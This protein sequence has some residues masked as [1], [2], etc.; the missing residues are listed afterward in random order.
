MAEIRLGALILA[1]GESKRMNGVKALLKLG[2][3]SAIEIVVN[4]YKEIGIQEIVV[5][6]G[7]H[8]GTIRPVVEKMGARVAIN[9]E[10]EKGM[11]SSIQ[12]GCLALKDCTDGFFMQ[13][14]DIP[15]VRIETLKALKEC[16]LLNRSHVI[17]PII[18]S[19]RGHPIIVSKSCY[20]VIDRQD[21]KFTMRD[22]LAHY[23]Y[24]H[25]ELPCVDEGI[26]WDMDTPEAYAQMCRRMKER[27]IPTLMECEMLWSVLKVSESTILHSRKV[28]E[29]ACRIGALLNRREEYNL[30]L[31]CLF[32]AGLMHD[33]RK[34]SK[35]HALDAATILDNYGFSGISMPVKYHMDLPRNKFSGH[36]TE[37]E[38]LYLADKMTKDSTLVRMEDRFSKMASSLPNENIEHFKLRVENAL[39]L[40]NTLEN[41]MEIIDL[42]SYLS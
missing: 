32:A 11:F 15:L 30:S 25:I 34:G 17:Y 28:A 2:E 38:V 42:F 5:V 26:L 8:Q 14:V 20:T 29:V 3:L 27:H 22:L 19:H 31:R 1:A 10:P 41:Q 16:Y 18:M 12:V 21:L 6:L 13:P 37:V 4:K 9:P 24:N 36:F 40:K 23:E 39:L 7:Y 33:I 35:D